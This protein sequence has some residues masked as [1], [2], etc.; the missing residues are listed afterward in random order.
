MSDI[1]ENP[2]AEYAK[3]DTPEE[4]L[5]ACREALDIDVDDN[6]VVAIE[7]LQDERET[8]QATVDEHTQSHRTELEDTIL[9]YTTFE[10]DELEQ[11]DT[12]MLA[13]L[14]GEF[15]RGAFGELNTADTTETKS[16]TDFDGI[17]TRMF[18]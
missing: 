1:D 18:Q 12:D 2:F 6:P 4:V 14:A 5:R 9:D 16:L 10:R 11:Y 15:E 3:Q 8:L 13:F 7:S 17:D